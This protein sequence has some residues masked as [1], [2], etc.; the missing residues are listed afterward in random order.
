MPSNYSDIWLGFYQLQE[1]VEKKMELAELHEELIKMSH[2]HAHAQHDSP[3][4][5]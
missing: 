4:K 2:A 1:L 3:K 5:T